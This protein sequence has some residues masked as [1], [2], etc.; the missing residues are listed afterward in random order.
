MN[1]YILRIFHFFLY[2]T[3]QIRDQ[4]EPKH[5][6]CLVY[7]CNLGLDARNLSLLHAHNKGTY[8]PTHSL[9]LIGAFVIRYLERK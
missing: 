9:S 7:I 5:V 6:Y 3:V 8:K 2:Y 4:H 1:K